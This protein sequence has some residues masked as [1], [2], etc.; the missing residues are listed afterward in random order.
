MLVTGIEPQKRNKNRFSV[1]LDGKY[2]FSIS[3]ET[4]FKFHLK[5]NLELGQQELGKLLEYEKKHYGMQSAFRLLSYRERSKKEI[6]EN[7]KNKNIDEPIIEQISNRLEGLG[8][9]ND[10]KFALNLAN[11]RKSQGKGTEFI[12]NE[13]KIKGVGS[14]TIND[15]LSKLYSSDKEET[16][17]IINIAKKKLD[18]MKG[19][20]AN[21]IS[22]RLLGFLTRRGFPLDRV[23]KALKELR[24]DFKEENFD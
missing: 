18:T 20:G 22:R 16:A 9:L 11:Y 24:K 4:L 14:E 5:E 6:S 23:L 15:V 1:H 10:D 12:K 7:L 2:A 17:Q 13:L 21:I 8:Y 3:D 19:L